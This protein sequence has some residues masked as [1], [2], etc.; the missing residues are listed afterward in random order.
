MENKWICN[1]TCNIYKIIS[2]QTKDQ[3]EKGKSLMLFISIFEEV[4]WFCWTWRWKS[5]LLCF[6]R[7]EKRLNIFQ[8]SSST[9]M[10]LNWQVIVLT[11]CMFQCI[12]QILI[13]LSS[14]FF[15]AH[16]NNSH[17]SQVM[18]SQAMLLFKLHE[19]F[20]AHPKSELCL[21][22]IILFTT[23]IQHSIFTPFSTFNL[24]DG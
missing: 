6:Q 1:P 20:L 23:L 10:S 17:L 12:L 2:K 9:M 22:Y 8:F 15:S 11:I 14:S 16:V 5:S 3:N 18:L 24:F 21:V 13:N 19:N 4:R 7:V